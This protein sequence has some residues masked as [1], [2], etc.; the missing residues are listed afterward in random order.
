MTSRDRGWSVK[1]G[2]DHPVCK[3]LGIVNERGS[4]V[5]VVHPINGQEAD[6]ETVETRAHL[7]AASGEMYDTLVRVRDHWRGRAA[8]AAWYADIERAIEKAERR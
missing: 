4:W 8:G 7:M 3:T 5:A 1:G 6:K 2:F